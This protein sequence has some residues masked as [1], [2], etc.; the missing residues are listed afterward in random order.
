MS[1]LDSVKIPSEVMPSRSVLEDDLEAENFALTKV[2]RVEHKEE[3]HMRLC[4][5][6]R[7]QGAKRELQ[8][9]LSG[10]P[11]GG[12]TLKSRE[13]G[14]SLPRLIT[15]KRL[16]KEFSDAL[17]KVTVS[18]GEDVV[19]LVG[20]SAPDE[21]D[22][23]TL[24][25][26]DALAKASGPMEVPIDAHEEVPVPVETDGDT[27]G[28]VNALDEVPAPVGAAGDILEDLDALIKITLL[29]EDAGYKFGDDLEAMGIRIHPQESLDQS[30]V[31][32][33]A[34]KEQAS[35]ET[36]RDA[37]K[38]LVTTSNTLDQENDANARSSS[39]LEHVL[40]QAIEEAKDTLD[41]ESYDSN[42]DKHSVN[43]D[44][45]SLW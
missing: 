42:E 22:E 24:G 40:I 2:A 27:I 19:A 4:V 41:A 11:S 45:L 18:E 34:N 37:H 9:E 33:A 3:S 28:V 21:A 15:V 32:D 26:M 38:G 25:A 14:L 44:G 16:Q 7:G 29:K 1:G 23:E 36:V 13:A 20:V 43:V 6:H 8:V 39:T 17:D 12:E 10:D 31:D 5:V 35:V 30:P